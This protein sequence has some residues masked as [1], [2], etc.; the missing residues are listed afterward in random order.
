MNRPFRISL[1]QIWHTYLVAA[2]TLIC[3]GGVSVYPY[4]LRMPCILVCAMG[5]AATLVMRQKRVS[6]APPVLM[7]LLTLAYLL[8]SVS[9]SYASSVTGRLVVVYFCCTMML[10]LSF[11]ESLFERTIKAM[12]IVCFIIALSIILSFFVEDCMNRY[13]SFIVNPLNNE[14]IA[15]TIRMEIRYSRSYSGFAREKAEAAF[16]M[17]V[18]ISL[19]LSR[20]FSGQKF[21]FRDGACLAL[22]FFALVLTGKRMLFLC[23]IVCCAALMLLF[24]KHGIIY[25]FLPAAVVCLG[26][27]YYI[28]SLFP[29]FRTVFDRFLDR[30]TMQTLTGRTSLWEYSFAMFRENPL[31]GLGL[32]SFNQ[33]ANDH[34]I[35]ATSFAYGH[36]IYFELLG[37]MGIIGSVL[38]FGALIGTFVTTI[39]LLKQNNA[40]PGQRRLLLF[41][42]SI[43][44]ICF[45]YGFTGNVLL[46]HQQIFIWYFAAAICFNIRKITKQQ[47]REVLR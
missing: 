22:L 21:R 41:S 27:I 42:F 33:F 43:Q 23:P 34:T 9:Y 5:F 6:I 19:S 12:E 18:G 7:F 17:N 37:E 4:N 28:L 39:L 24:D 31:F 13:F 30:E 25:R 36:N 15:E 26:A 20:L 44:L 46:Y 10:M 40:T 1:A 47:S 16:I 14:T 3:V 2:I 8:V 38:L 29:D 32:G 11:P 35:D 45:V